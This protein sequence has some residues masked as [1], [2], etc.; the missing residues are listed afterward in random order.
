MKKKK[1]NKSESGYTNENGVSIDKFIENRSTLLVEGEAK[2]YKTATD[3]NSY[4]YQVFHNGKSCG[5]YA[6]PK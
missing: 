3:N 4:Y 2:A 6:I 1:D 5:L